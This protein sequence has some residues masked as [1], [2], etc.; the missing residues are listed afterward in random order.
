MIFLGVG[1]QTRKALSRTLTRAF[2]RSHPDDPNVFCLLIGGVLLAI[3]IYLAY[4]WL[5]SSA[6]QENPEPE[7]TASTSSES[8]IIALLFAGLGAFFLI[9]GAPAN[10]ASK[11]NLT[12]TDKSSEIDVLATRLRDKQV[13]Q[14]DTFDID[15][16]KIRLPG[17]YEL[18]KLSASSHVGTWSDQLK[19]PKFSEGIP[20]VTPWKRKLIIIHEPKTLVEAPSFSSSRTDTYWTRK[21][22]EATDKPGS[23]EGENT[24]ITDPKL[25][26][27]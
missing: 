1:E 18:P 23:A 25:N 5:S 14:F 7:Q 8:A 21:R 26:G 2:Q 17:S 6:P 12:G 27:K 4:K 15:S 13:Q 22:R 20:A 11:G 24:G 3:G 9:L 16:F 19:L 10:P